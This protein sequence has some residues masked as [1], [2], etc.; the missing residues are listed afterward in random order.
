MADRE[1]NNLAVLFEDNIGNVKHE[2][3]KGR[4]G[5]KM[6]EKEIYYEYREEIE[7]EKSLKNQLSFKKVNVRIN[8]IIYLYQIIKMLMQLILN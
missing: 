1:S 8:G 2:R 7:N 6:N 3:R 4:K 5:R